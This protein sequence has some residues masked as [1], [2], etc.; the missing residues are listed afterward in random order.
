MEEISKQDEKR[1]LGA[2]ERAIGM[3][4]GGMHPTEALQKV[5]E[6]C[7]LTPPMIKRAV[8]AYNVS[9]M[10]N[11]LGH[12]KGAARADSFPI[13]SAETIIQGMYPEKPQ[14]EAAKAASVFVPGEVQ[15]AERTNFNKVANK[16]SDL[17]MENPLVAK[18][19][20]YAG[21]PELEVRRLFA[22]RAS[23]SKAEDEALSTVRRHYFEILG[24]AKQ[25]SSQFRFVAHR[26]FAQVE[27][28]IVAE[29]GS[30]G[31]TA[32]D[33]IYATGNL[34][35]KRA[36]I[37]E[38]HQ[39]YYNQNDHPYRT[40]TALVR[41]SREFVK[42]AE[43]AAKANLAVKEFEHSMG[44]RQPTTKTAA[45]QLDSILGDDDSEDEHFVTKLAIETPPMP[46]I[47]PAVTDAMK[48]IAHIGMS[49]A[50]AKPKPYEEVKEEVAR[51]VLDPV[52][53][54]K[55][56]G[57]RTQ[58]ILNDFISNDPVLSTYNPADVA[59]AYNQVAELS[60]S[61]SQQPAVLRGVLRRMMQQEGVIEPFEA[62]QLTGVERHLRGMP[63]VDLGM[64]GGQ[65]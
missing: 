19:E 13:A 43:V 39:P 17:L 41:E 62:Q 11:H 42:A 2:L 55:M 30:I 10:L 8:E 5:A 4:N 36:E 23:L 28:D 52:H 45:R 24:L 15:K 54:Q 21:D 56:Q 27:Q 37:D 63:V 48:N 60:P 58:A 64:G 1:V 57:I 40:V 44:G 33:L 35:E 65:K 18:P 9:K 32:M 51:D 14:S 20:P 38:N 26:P 16:F 61:V 50:G 25:A 22:K 3:A 6:E 53:E 7:R 29:Y 31:K 59:K 46:G 49:M 34:T 12:V 47:H